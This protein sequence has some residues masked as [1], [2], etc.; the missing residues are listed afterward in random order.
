M[1]KNSGTNSLRSLIKTGFGLSIGFML[2][3][4]LF[5]FIGLAFF[6]PG[7]FMYM[8]NKKSPDSSNKIFSIILMA[9]G[10]IIMGGVG[11]GLLLD[12]MG[13]MFD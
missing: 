11:F 7:Y 5:I 3:Q 9:I 12:N 13:D 4:V 2:G 1:A 10:V 8:K 6:L